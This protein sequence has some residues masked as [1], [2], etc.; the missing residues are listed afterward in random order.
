MIILFTTYFLIKQNFSFYQYRMNSANNIIIVAY[1]NLIHNM[2]I[3]VN[4]NY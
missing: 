1:N 3:F 2:L 4:L